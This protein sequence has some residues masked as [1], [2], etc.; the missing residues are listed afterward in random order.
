MVFVLCGVVEDM[1]VLILTLSLK[2]VKRLINNH[3]NLKMIN[4]IR[5]LIKQDIETKKC[6][7]GFN[8]ANK[9]TAIEDEGY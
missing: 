9:K 1:E 3:F 6:S 5:T 7:L 4:K 2:V 8:R